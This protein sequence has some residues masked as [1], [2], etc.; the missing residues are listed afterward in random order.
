LTGRAWGPYSLAL[1]HAAQAKRGQ[2]AP[3][4]WYIVCTEPATPHI[5]T[6]YAARMW[7]DELFRDL[8]SQGFHPA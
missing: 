2:Q 8:K 7:A 1:A 5:L 6:L 4:P 3:D